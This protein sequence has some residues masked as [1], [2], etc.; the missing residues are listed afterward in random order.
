M[1]FEDT[2]RSF[3]FEAALVA[4]LPTLIDAYGADA[5]DGAETVRTLLCHWDDAAHTRKRAGSLSHGTV[6]PS[7]RPDGRLVVTGLWSTALIA[8]W[9]SGAIAGAIEEL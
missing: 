6:K 7:S 5:P 1:T 4:Q 8:A 2:P 9:Q 3:A